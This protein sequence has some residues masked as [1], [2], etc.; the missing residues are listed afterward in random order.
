K[1][2]EAFRK[3][4]DLLPENPLPSYYL[5][6]SL[7]LIGQ[8][9]EAAKAFERAL[10]R[11]PA[12]GEMLE[13][14][15]ALGQVHQRAQRYDQALAVWER[16]EKILPDDLRVKEQ[17]AGALAEE[18]QEKEALPRYEA[19]AGKVRDSYRRVQLKLEAA[20]L[21]VK[22]GRTRDALADFEGLLGTVE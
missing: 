15:Q 16:L 6:Q 22:L 3:A 1:A 11:K 10:E 17:I 13:I 18:G 19:L 20:E 12:R 4:E 8:P 9:E 21:K 5:G 7:V 14:Y 2:V